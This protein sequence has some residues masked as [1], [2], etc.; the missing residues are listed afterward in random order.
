MKNVESHSHRI[1]IVDD[2]EDMRQTLIDALKL[3]GYQCLA[4]DSG[5]S[6]LR[7][8]DCNRFDLVIS[9][10]RMP[11]MDGIQLLEALKKRSAPS[12][13]VILMTASKSEVLQKQAFELGAKEVILKPIASRELAA[14]AARTIE[15]CEMD[16]GG[17]S[18]RRSD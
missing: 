9:D 10:C 13:P 7:C 2:N 8:L 18:E 12:P 1:L 11:I 14:L 17:F 15:S 16:Q 3:H 6:A 5:E 4:A